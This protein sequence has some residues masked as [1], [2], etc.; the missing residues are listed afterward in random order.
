MV[1]LV[2]ATKGTMQILS[3]A[4]VAAESKLTDR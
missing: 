3:R 2:V 1:D 4:L